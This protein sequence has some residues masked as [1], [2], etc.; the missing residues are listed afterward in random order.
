MRK[1]TDGLVFKFAIVM[2]FFAFITLSLTGFIT[3]VSQTR[4]YKKQSC[5]EIQSL[6]YYLKELIL[7]QGEDFINYH[8]QHMSL[9]P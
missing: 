7:A 6:G 2:A 4:V 8:S 9:I 3:Y 1:I 5:E